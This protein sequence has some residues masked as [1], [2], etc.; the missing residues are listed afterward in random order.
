MRVLFAALVC[1][2]AILGQA[3]LAQTD[4]PTVPSASAQQAAPA[5]A[6]PHLLKPI[7]TTSGSR[8]A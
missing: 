7:V 5:A 2:G 3:V 1:S 8:S 4:N 6:T